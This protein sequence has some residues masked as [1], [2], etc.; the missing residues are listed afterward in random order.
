MQGERLAAARKRAGLRQ[1]D[2]AAALG[3][4]YDQTMIS[5][6]ESGYSAM[7]LDGAVKAARKLGVSLDYLVG[8]T[9]DPTPSAEL[10]IAEITPEIRQL[11]GARPVPVRRLRTAAGSGAV[12]LDEEVEAYAYFGHEWLSRQGLVADR[13][14]IISVMGELM[15]PTLAEN[16]VVLVDHNRKRRLKGHIF[17]V[18]KSDGLVVKRAGKDDSGDW[19]LESDHPAWEPEP[20][21]EG[22]G[23]RR[24]QV[25]G[26]GTVTFFGVT[27]PTVST[28]ATPT[29][30]QI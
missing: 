7:L 23:H 8:L 28:V 20:W 2:L 24:S 18:R 9:D 26:Q 12:D 10:S 29:R 27:F 15:E 30:P 16:C 25:D 1:V 5:H 3:D 19:L 22:R 21:G 17:V 13:C 6:V 14:S 11:P 4:R